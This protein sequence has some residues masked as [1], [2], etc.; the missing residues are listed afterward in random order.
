MGARQEN[1]LG[2]VLRRRLGGSMREDPSEQ[3]TSVTVRLVLR[4]PNVRPEAQP[5]RK[6]V[7][8]G[9]GALAA[10][11]AALGQQ[12][13]KGASGRCTAAGR[14]HQMLEVQKR[15][16]AWQGRKQ[17]H[18]SQNVQC[19]G[20]CCCCAGSWRWRAA[21]DQRQ[22][23]AGG[24]CTAIERGIHMR[25]EQ[26]SVASREVLQACHLRKGMVLAALFVAAK[27]NDQSGVTLRHLRQGPAGMDQ[28]GPHEYWRQPGTAGV[29]HQGPLEGPQMGHQGGYLV[30]GLCIACCQ[31]DGACRCWGQR[32]GSV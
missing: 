29:S 30:P 5:H 14:L 2:T 6:G 31:N 1:C 27:R 26:Q 10:A 9:K 15:P 32:H 3:L 17:D 8:A 13:P 28:Q 20:G 22:S 25:S 18:R 24:R 23:G 7:V 19:G 4:V 11:A 21:A 16:G 12:P